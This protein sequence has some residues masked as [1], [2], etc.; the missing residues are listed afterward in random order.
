MAQFG[1]REGLQVELG[2]GQEQLAG[3]A[4]LFKLA[5]VGAEADLL[6][7]DPTPRDIKIACEH[8]E[9]AFEVR[10]RYDATAVTNSLLR[11]RCLG[12]PSPTTATPRK[13]TTIVDLMSARQMAYVETALPGGVLG[14]VVCPYASS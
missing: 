3:G 4:V 14:W 12:V 1:D 2:E 8:F 11:W 10:T 6:C 13:P 5:L 7:L 9:S